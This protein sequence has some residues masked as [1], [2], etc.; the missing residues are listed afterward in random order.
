MFSD[1]WMLASWTYL[2]KT[3]LKRLMRLT[4]LRSYGFVKSF[5]IIVFWYYPLGWLSRN[6]LPKIHLHN[7]KFSSLVG[8]LLLLRQM[9]QRNHNWQSIKLKLH[10][11]FMSNH[12][13]WPPDYRRFLWHNRITTLLTTY[14][15]ALQRQQPQITCPYQGRFRHLNN[16]PVLFLVSTHPVGKVWK[17]YVDAFI[18]LFA[19]N[20]SQ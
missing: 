15:V 14:N 10:V 6:T 13:P 19:E 20:Q 3:K 9:V 11:F 4:V 17:I 5:I 16:W 18:H 2:N 1:I 7:I 8:G 12:Q